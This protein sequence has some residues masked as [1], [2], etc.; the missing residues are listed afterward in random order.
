MATSNKTSTKS[1]PNRGRTI[2]VRIERETVAD[3]SKELD[4][5]KRETDAKLKSL[6][7]QINEL[8]EKLAAIE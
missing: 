1:L 7:S 4:K 3:V 6:Q 2:A 5:H 8:K